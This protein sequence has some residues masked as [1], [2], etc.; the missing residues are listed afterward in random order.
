MQT[1]DITT[2]SLGCTD[3]ARAHAARLA[4]LRRLQRAQVAE[5][6][7]IRAVV[8]DR[9]GL[10]LADLRSPNRQRTVAEARQ[11]A[12]YLMRTDLRWPLGTGARARNALFPAQRIGRLLGGRDHA[13]V[14]HGV[15]AIAARLAGDHTLRYMVRSIR[16][17]LD[18][19]YETTNSL[20]SMTMAPTRDGRGQGDDRWMT[21]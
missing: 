11:V 3:D 12:M 1:V 21:H 15:G 18:A 13:T 9:Y 20:S 8:T 10:T 2:P 7:R 16:A 17:T 4:A 6:R 19:T 14:L 5:A